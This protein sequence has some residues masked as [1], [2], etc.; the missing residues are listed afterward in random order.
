MTKMR[1]HKHLPSETPLSETRIHDKFKDWLSNL[2][3][4]MKKAK[5]EINGAT[6]AYQKDLIKE[7]RKKDFLRTFIILCELAFQ[8]IDVEK[9]KTNLIDLI[10][11]VIGYVIGDIIF[12]TTDIIKLNEIMK[13][14]EKTYLFSIDMRFE[15][16][17]NNGNSEKLV[18]EFK[19]KRYPLPKNANIM[20]KRDDK[21]EIT[22]EKK[23]LV[24]KE[25]ENLN[26]YEESEE[27]MQWINDRSKSNTRKGLG[28]DF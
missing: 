19:A 27:F 2:D 16:D 9:E 8:N 24:M 11:D 3:E 21:W 25:G 14:L 20:K 23:F 4:E 26:I 6:E 18:N 5:D 1:K 17:L 10:R 7:N 12:E 15:E 22:N 28:N 13:Y